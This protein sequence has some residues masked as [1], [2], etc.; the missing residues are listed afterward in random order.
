MEKFSD[1]WSNYVNCHVRLVESIR[2]V[3]QACDDRD[4]DRL[5]AAEQTMH[6][7]ADFALYAEHDVDYV[8]HVCMRRRDLDKA[9][10]S[11]RYL[12]GSIKRQVRDMIWS[13]RPIERPFVHE[14]IDSLR[15][16]L[17]SMHKPEVTDQ[18]VHDILDGIGKRL[19]GNEDNSDA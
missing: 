13:T 14:D 9:P 6:D 2:S 11:V 3:I 18:M 19:V 4:R 7:C 12:A 10:N 8:V 5:V 17:E 16:Q 15:A 1:Q